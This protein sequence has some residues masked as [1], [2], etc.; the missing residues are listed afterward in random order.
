VTGFE[1]GYLAAEPFLLPLH[2]T[3][4]RRLLQ[5]GRFAPP[6]EILDVG[7][8]KSHYTIGLPARVTITDRPRETAIQQ[9][10][11]LGITPDIAEATLAR[12]SNVREIRFDDMTRSALPDAAFDYALAV[13]V[14]E[15]VDDDV[16]FVD[17]VHRVL[18]PRG[19]FLMTTPNGDAVANTNPDHRRHY[20]REQLRAL[21]AARFDRV[22]V[23]YAI[24]GGTFRTLGLRSWSV[25]HPWTT[26]LS[27]IGNVVNGVQSGGAGVKEDA[28]RTRHLMAVAWKA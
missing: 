23:E 28:N 6:P 16:R 21:L 14:L 7:G 24:R 13:E 19:A 20:L 9:Q 12:R 27:M 5:I 10:L 17:E 11:H 22:E 8:R 4:R 3:V 25:R 26:A 15:H 1:I 2:R 18:K